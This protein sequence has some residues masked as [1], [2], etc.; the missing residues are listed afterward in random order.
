MQVNSQA[1]GSGAGQLES[2]S[3]AFE[4]NRSPLSL[5]E[6]LQD[7][8][9]PHEFWVLDPWAYWF[10]SFWYAAPFHPA[11]DMGENTSYADLDMR[12]TTYLVK[13]IS[14]KFAGQ[15]S[16]QGLPV[17][18]FT[19]DTSNLA[20]SRAAWKVEAAQGEVLVSVDANIPLYYQ[21][22]VRGS[23]LANASGPNYLPG[24]V[25]LTK[26]LSQINQPLKIALPANYPNLATEPGFP[27]PPG[28]NLQYL[29]RVNG[30]TQYLYA[31]QVSGADFSAY[32]AG[33][34]SVNGWS[35]AKTGPLQGNSYTC[36]VCVILSN[37]KE[38]VRVV[39]ESEFNRT[40][41]WVFN[42]PELY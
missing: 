31:T 19:F 25:T 14:A 10:S 13:V 3:K 23:I 36:S 4:Y 35:V 34:A 24:Q 5:H 2:Y 39:W 18:R 15:E 26:A 38:Q 20:E 9:G 27:L 1:S 42:P 30:V 37:G 7:V 41:I 8:N 29:N 40:V 16:Y 33:L 12:L 32:Y 6:K 28:V 11:T 22:T 17:Y 21:V